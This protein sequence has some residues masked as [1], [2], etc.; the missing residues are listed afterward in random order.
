MNA[1][2]VARGKPQHCCVTVALIMI[3]FKTSISLSSWYNY[4][5]QPCEHRIAGQLAQHRFQVTTRVLGGQHIIL[6]HKLEL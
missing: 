3:I 2:K 6:R 5:L 1:A 4:L